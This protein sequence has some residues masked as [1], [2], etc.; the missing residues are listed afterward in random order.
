MDG[1][2]GLVVAVDDLRV[3]G[4]AATVIVR[5]VARFVYYAAGGRGVVVL[6]LR[7]CK[8]P[9]RRSFNG[10]IWS[11]YLKETFTIPNP[12]TD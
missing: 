10:N 6:G 5:H 1:V 3:G 9:S 4:I 12:I 2:E 7:R 8:F 11:I